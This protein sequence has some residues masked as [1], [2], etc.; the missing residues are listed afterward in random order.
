MVINVKY[1]ISISPS[2]VGASST[3][4]SHL[5]SPALISAELQRTVVCELR[6]ISHI[7]RVTYLKYAV[8]GFPRPQGLSD[9]MGAHLACR[10][11]LPRSTK[12]LMTLGEILQ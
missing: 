5:L 2:K 8:Y 4:V 9:T 7:L 10:Q 11:V 1:S 6:F 3:S 12:R